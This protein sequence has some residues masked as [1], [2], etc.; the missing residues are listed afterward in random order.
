MNIIEAEDMVKGL[1]DQVLFQ[2]AQNPPPTIPQFLAISEV[3]RRQDMRQRFQAQQQEQKGTVKDQILQGIGGTGMAPEMS[4]P[5][6]MA[7]SMPQGGPPPGGPPQG[8]PIGMAGGGSVPTGQAN[9]Q[10]LKNF[11]QR[12]FGTPQGLATN[13][14]TVGGALLGGPLGSVVGANIGSYIG[15]RMSAP[16]QMSDWDRMRLFATPFSEAAKQQEV[17]AEP[18]PFVDGMFMGGQVPYRMQEGRQAPSEQEIREAL[19]TLP[20]NRTPR[21]KEIARAALSSSEYNPGLFPK[22]TSR[23]YSA[24]YGNPQMPGAE[25]PAAPAAPAPV[26][27][28]PAAAPARPPMVEAGI[29]TAGMALA[30]ATPPAAPVA[31]PAPP[32]APPMAAAVT[33]PAPPVAPPAAPLTAPTGFADPSAQAYDSLLS[34][35]PQTYEAVNKLMP[36]VGGINAAELE[37]FKPTQSDYINPDAVRQREELLAQ[38][39]AQGEARRKE[40]ISAAERAMKESEAPIQQASDEARRAAIA[41]TLMRLGSGLA[42]GKPAEGLASASESVEQ[43]MG[44]AR[45]QAAAERRAS[46]QEFRAAEREATRAERSVADT[47][48]QMQASNITANENAQRDF[49]RD[50]K[51]FAQWA[52]GQMRDAGREARQ[53]QGDAIKLSIGITQSID[54]AVRDALKTRAVS[55]NQYTETFG[56]VFKEVLKEIK[57]TDWGTDD[58]GNEIVPTAEQLLKS[59]SEQTD[60]VLS[61]RG[62]VSPSSIVTVT[63]PQELAALESGKRYRGPD[64]IV[65][66]KP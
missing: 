60:A 33:P 2:Y 32:V 16:A 1:P 57:T 62:I 48:F 20:I 29:P 22:V 17:P 46:R 58:E 26:A 56:T 64:G 39:R 30:S 41:S 7:P 63:T 11:L 5:P 21:Q 35:L 14:G 40:D 25:P 52:Y 49:V 13:I 24:M 12:N 37:R 38:L 34:R 6:P 27:P 45:E 4:G 8:A 53:A 19:S 9:P 59:A 18:P 44:R 28:R 51:S 31:P 23:L 65:R 47:A 43:I 66:V 15:D 3:Q 10:V 42:A 50:Q 36:Q 61:R 55:E 54:Q